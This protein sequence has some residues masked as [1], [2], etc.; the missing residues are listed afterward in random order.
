MAAAYYGLKAVSLIDAEKLP[1]GANVVLFLRN[2][3]VSTGARRKLR[4]TRVLVVPI[5]SF[6]SSI[7][8]ALYTQKLVT[9]TDYDDVSSKTAYWADSLRSK[10]GALVFSGSPGEDGAASGTYLVC[11]LAENLRADAWTDSEIRVGD[12]ISVGLICELSLTAPSAKDW[13][14]AFVIDGR[15]VASGVLVAKDARCTEAGE[16]RIRAAHTLRDE[17]AAK[18]PVDLRIEN[19]ILTSARAGGEDFTSAL[20]E[21][22]NPE[23]GLHVL[24]LGIGTNQSVLPHVK[25]NI[26]SQLNEGAGPV[27]IGFG[28]GTTGAHVDFVIEHAEHEFKVLNDLA[29]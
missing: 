28:E 24:E 17:L 12:W 19:G 11:R 9:L 23:Y 27:H 3:L 4:H 7:E 2:E 16:A 14:G 8:V 22:T 25:W 5:A 1:P 13:Y 21:V 20:L 15:A 6:D 10:E 26:N 29:V 18:G